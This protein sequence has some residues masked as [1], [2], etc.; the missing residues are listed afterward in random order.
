M[1]TVPVWDHYFSHGFTLW[2]RVAHQERAL[3]CQPPCFPQLLAE[4]WESTRGWGALGPLHSHWN[5]GAVPHCWLWPRSG[6]CGHLGLNYQTAGLFL[7]PS[8][9]LGLGILNTKVLAHYQYFPSWTLVWGVECLLPVGTLGCDRLQ[10]VGGALSGSEL[11]TLTLYLPFPFT[12]LGTN[13][14]SFFYCLIRKD[15]TLLTQNTPP[16]SSSLCQHLP[17]GKVKLSYNA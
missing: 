3:C 9:S 8:P 4:V 6:H 12:S 10:H 1:V 7:S 15:S 11:S 5:A 17:W 16:F 13:G 14:T 2:L